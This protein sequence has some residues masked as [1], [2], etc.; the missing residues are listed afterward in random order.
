[1]NKQ[2]R[3]SIEKQAE[4]LGTKVYKTAIRKNIAIKKAQALRTNIFEYDSKSN[5]AEDYKN[6]IEEFKENE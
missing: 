5:G 2:F 3:E 1:M 6:F 4:R